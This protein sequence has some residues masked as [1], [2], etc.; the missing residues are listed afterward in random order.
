MKWIARAAMSDWGQ[1]NP[2]LNMFGQKW[3]V[4]DTRVDFIFCKPL[5]PKH[6]SRFRLFNSQ[7]FD[8][9]DH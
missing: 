4:R 9:K 8:D 7:E 5:Q 2:Y 1:A 3:R 6:I